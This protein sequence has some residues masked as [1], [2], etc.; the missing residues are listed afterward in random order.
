VHH[1]H[2]GRDLSAAL[3]AA[4][5]GLRAAEGAASR[6]LTADLQRRRARLLRRLRAAPQA[7]SACR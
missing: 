6:D 3:D 2:R 4:D 5:R 1:E 7:S